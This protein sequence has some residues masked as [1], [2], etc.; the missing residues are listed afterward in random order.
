[1]LELAITL[2]NQ[3]VI[4]DRLQDVGAKVTR[5]IVDAIRL[6]AVTDVHAYVAAIVGRY[7]KRIPA[8]RWSR[9]CLGKRPVL[10]PVRRSHSPVGQVVNRSAE[11][12]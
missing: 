2:E 12:I 3:R 7:P 6:K 1:M 4:G 8:T 11:P 10:S 9:W 5:A